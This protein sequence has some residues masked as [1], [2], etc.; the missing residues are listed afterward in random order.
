[1]GMVVGAIVAAAPIEAAAQ[2]W[3]RTFQLSADPVFGNEVDAPFGDTIRDDAEYSTTLVFRREIDDKV[4]LTVT[5]FV[6]INPNQF[7]DDDRASSAGLKIDIKRPFEITNYVGGTPQD[8]ISPFAAYSYGRTFEGEF[9]HQ[10]GSSHTLD[11]GLTY[12]DVRTFACLTE[13]ATKARI[14]TPECEAGY[15]YRVTAAYQVVRSSTDLEDLEGP[16]LEAVVET[17]KWRGVSLN[18]NSAWQELNFDDAVGFG[19]AARQD[20]R[21]RLT[22]SLN[23]SSLVQNLFPRLPDTLTVSL[24]VR[25]AENDSNAPGA[26]YERRYFVPSIGWKRTF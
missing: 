14:S 17:P 7:D 5:P 1:M 21:L 13:G 15:L 24:G 26:D 12:E 8:K 20:R 25:Y 16:R 10:S 2:D 23:V 3:G 6:K 18:L 4:T 22:A 9:R 19:G 11:V